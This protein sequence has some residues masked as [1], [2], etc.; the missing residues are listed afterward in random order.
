MSSCK[1][2]MSECT[3]G[4]LCAAHGPLDVSHIRL[5]S[6]CQITSYQAAAAWKQVGW[7]NWLSYDVWWPPSVCGV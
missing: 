6:C 7:Q 1:M 4:C 5:D 3:E 2:M